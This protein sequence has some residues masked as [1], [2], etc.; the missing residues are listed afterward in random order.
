MQRLLR[1]WVIGP[2]WC[3]KRKFGM[4]L[5][6]VCCQVNSLFS[7]AF[8]VNATNWCSC[9]R[10]GSSRVVKTTY[11]FCNVQSL[12]EPCHDTMLFFEMLSWCERVVLI[13]YFS[14]HNKVAP[15]GWAAAKP[16]GN[17]NAVP[18]TSS[19]RDNTVQTKRATCGNVPEI[20]N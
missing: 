5:T 12:F 8:P 15:A 17:P 16:G 18:E 3:K 4:S 11:M 20:C 19:G 10:M 2:S 6:S 7:F 14:L 13:M 9:A 1:N